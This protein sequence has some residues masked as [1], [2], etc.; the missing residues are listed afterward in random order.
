[1]D[2]K[3]IYLAQRNPAVSVEDWPRTWRSHA[4]Y[5]ATF[6]VLGA[7]ITG[8]YYCA[9]IH[10]PTLD[11]APVEVP[12]ASPDHD[13]VAV[14]SSPFGVEVGGELRPEDRE[15]ILEDERRVFRILTPNFSFR[16]AETL[17]HGGAPGR[18]AVVRFLAR[19]P[20]DAQDAFLARWNGAHAAQAIAAAEASGGFSRYVH[21]EMRLPPPPGYPFD[22][23]SETWFSTPDDAVRFLLRPEPAESRDLAEFCDLSRSVTMLTQVVH[24][25]RQRAAA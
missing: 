6:P 11:G 14:I 3:L 4:Q 18:A 16:C 5:A 19:R 23:I 15:K 22:G 25:W 8:L 2:Y 7:E 24:S 9:R 17:S 12:A 13:G 21:N 20:K 1:M 10:A